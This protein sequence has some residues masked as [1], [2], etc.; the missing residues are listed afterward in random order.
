MAL[1][2]RDLFSCILMVQFY[3]FSICFS[4]GIFKYT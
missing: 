3:V 2:E 4:I 1:F